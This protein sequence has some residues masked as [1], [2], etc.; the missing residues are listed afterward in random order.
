M[1]RSQCTTDARI[2]LPNSTRCL[3]HKSRGARPDETPDSAKVPPPRTISPRRVPSIRLC[4]GHWQ[5]WCVRYGN[6]Q[7]IGIPFPPA[8]CSHGA[9]LR[10][11]WKY[12][13]S[14]ALPS[15]CA[16]RDV[17]T[18]DAMLLRWGV[19]RV[20]AVPSGTSIPRSKCPQSIASDEV[21]NQELC[22]LTKAPIDGDSGSA[23][24][25]REVI[26]QATL[27][28]RSVLLFGL[29]WSSPL[30]VPRLGGRRDF[31]RQVNAG[32]PS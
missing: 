13:R 23:A 18:F 25:G 24:T 26:D 9:H 22:Q 2:E 21:N 12:V 28:R 8:I 11:R 16:T 32:R 31:N 7:S 5:R 19:A 30:D 29:R 20:V 6:Q 3:R 27:R 1:V 15:R 17:R 14:G 10:I 4:G